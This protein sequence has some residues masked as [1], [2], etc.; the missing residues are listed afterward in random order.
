MNQNMMNDKE[1]RIE[2]LVN[3]F[4]TSCAKEMHALRYVLVVVLMIIGGGVNSAWGQTVSSGLYYIASGGNDGTV[5]QFVYNSNT[6]ETNFYLCP[7]ENWRYFKSESPYY[8]ES[9]NG[10]PF[11][12]TYQCLNDNNYDS[13]NALWCIKKKEDTDYYY[14]IHLLDGKYLT[15]NTKIGHGCNQGRMRIHLESSPADD[16]DALF[17]ITYV[18]K[19]DCYDIKTKKNDGASDDDALR[20]YMNVSGGNK[21]SKQGA[22]GKSDGP[23]INGTGSQINVGG[24]I[25]LWTY[26]AYYPS[27]ESKNDQNSRWCP[28]S[29]LLTAPTISDVDALTSKV[30][31][32][33]NNSLPS[34]YNI[35]YTTNGDDPTA[36]S[37]IMSNGVYDVTVSC[38]LKVVLERYGVVLTEVAEKSVA[39]VSCATP[40]ISFDYTTS[41]VSITCA[42][43]GANI[44]YTTDGSNPTASSTPYNNTP[45]SVTS[46]TTIK[47][48]AT[49]TTLPNSEVATLEIT[50][51]ATPTIQNNGSNAISI[52]S[53]TDGATIYY[54]IDG[55]NPTTASTPYTVPLT[56][57]VSG[58]TIKAIAVKENMII[59]EVG[60]G[61][62]TLQCADPVIVRSGNNGFTISCP[63]P[64]SGVTIYYTTNGSN[65]T[66]SSSSTTSGSTIPCTL[67][68]TVNA[69]A[70]ATNYNNSTVTSTYLTQG[71]GGDGSDADP[72]TIEYQSDV[73]DFNTKANT[74]AE[75]SKHYKVIATGSLDFSGVDITRDFSGTFDGGLC[76][77][78]GL[79]HALFNKVNGGTV[80]NVILKGVNIQS[81]DGDGDAGAICNKAEGSSVI[82]NCGILPTTT[83]R[84]DDG[85]ITGF[86]GST[87]SGNRN[88]GGLVGFLNGTSRVINCYSY[89]NIMGGSVKAGIVGY[90]NYA[91]KYNDLKTMV[92]NCMFYGNIATG[93]SVYP[94]YGGL[95][96]SNDYKANT[97]NRLNNYNYF[98]YE[99]PF[100]KN[101]HTT[102]PT[103]TA[104]NCALAAEERYL[105]RFEFYRHLLNSN[106]ELAAWYAT[107]D[108]ANG[109]GIGSDNKMLKWVLD[110]SIAPY[111]ILKV[112][113]KYPSVVNYD[114]EYTYNSSGDKVT[115]ASVT[116][117]NKG[118]IVSTL[119]SSG[120][121][122]IN[123]QMGSGGAIFDKPTG[124]SITTASLSRPIIDKDFD[125]YNFNYGKVQLPYY[126]EVGTKNY[127]G[128][129][130][131]T[132]WKIVSMT[133]GTSGGY[134]ETDY[135][136]PNYNY[137]DRD[138]YGKDIYGTGGSGR[139]F[140][141]GAYF[142]V[143]TGVTA[144][145]IEPYW[146][147]CA[148]LSNKYYDRYGYNTTDDL[149]QIGGSH[150]DATPTITIDGSAQ[151]VYTTLA[152]ARSSM[153]ETYES[154]STVYDHAIV[155]VG[156]YHH[157]TNDAAGEGDELNSVTEKP[158]TITSVDLNE[159]NEPDYCL[160]FRSG[161]QKP[162]APIRYDFITV[163]G[164]A[165]A[166]K[167]ATHDNLAI[168]GNCKPRGW[169]E[170]TTT[171]L[172]KFGQFEHSWEQKTTAPLILMGGIFDQ[173]V[174]NN[175]GNGITY[176][177]RTNYIL[178][179]DNV[180]F[181]L[182]SD[183][184][185]SD[186]TSPTP[187]RPISITGGEFDVL[188]L[189]GYFKP[190][191]TA[192]TEGNGD[193]NAKCYIDGGKFGEVAGAGQ[194]KIDGDVT[195]II[196]HADID[197]F[198]GGGINSAKAITGNI[199]T[200]IK[201]SHVDVFCGGPKFGNMASNKTVVTEA[202]G[203][204]FRKYFGGGFGGT[205][206]Y[207]HRF[208][209]Q[210][211]SLNYINDGKG[212][213]S[214]WI[215]NSYDGSSTDYYR[216]KY[217]SGK[218]VAVN[219][220]YEFFGGS[221]G[222]VAR[223]YIDYASFSLAQTNG[224]T[225]TLTGCTIKEN[226]YGGGSLGAVMGDATSTLTNCTV[227][228]KVFGAGYSVDI[229]TV[230]VRNL[231]GWSVVPYY[232]NSTAVFEEPIWQSE[233]T[234][235]WDTQSVSVGNNALVDDGLKIKTNESL[236]GLG[237][238]TGNVT[239][240]L[241]G[242]TKVGY[243]E[244]GN[245][246][247]GGGN[248]YGGGEA[249]AV[250]GSGH[251]VTV[252]LGGS[253]TV[254]GDVF[255]G[256]DQGEVEGSTK[257]NIMYTEPTP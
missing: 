249:S 179:G 199:H 169:F 77:L 226:F 242:T 165:M 153:G 136:A 1:Q 76:V 173:F 227:L 254:L 74:A 192:C 67:P 176:T 10:M 180:W 228:G 149:S 224:V 86:T 151:T 148:Y 22:S 47:A 120:S 93:G 37:T 181:Q 117:P 143:P 214:N 108:A 135:D 145:T 134:T 241:N 85:N 116:E 210:W 175:S 232:N 14:I 198:Y 30:T 156:N 139:I 235:T 229:P 97:A 194:E 78:T 218:G 132:G 133:G 50:Q 195:W 68:I 212:D 15:R 41:E 69:F 166:L 193:R 211:E 3:R 55:T 45:F 182:L 36:S 168:P 125:Q 213:W 245:P 112:Q 94:I 57:N 34:G 58:V 96:I 16:D 216:G 159:D 105:V 128:N 83:N 118:G 144:I 147:K 63:F 101:N 111:P 12:T 197:N 8:Q 137:A 140:A 247:D 106:R 103:I 38:T 23:K 246:V 203:C 178:L 26:G 5:N 126:N 28:K 80:K 150:Y 92:M 162:V 7:T 110:K 60:S 64:A 253:T 209:N 185:H 231:G 81:G 157:H 29:T 9:D 201:N 164:M 240:T 205:S 160:I 190:E 33:D 114:E 141:Q 255:G 31:I 75:A 170:V 122:T 91:S 4:M 129:R 155:L 152:S 18:S 257:V 61:S 230:N 204:T 88:V 219:Y 189:S 54:T 237:A 172:I 51:V 100:S 123:I 66:T 99:A 130:V 251:T 115:R 87:V 238:V 234:Y 19:F 49:H 119:G 109:K 79:S 250:K 73:S 200:T 256:G 236:E 17:T 158:L 52:T 39:P 202:T 243:D 244:D 56:E 174:S 221:K 53:A 59:S 44:Y 146:A 124:A 21:N 46:P 72:Y 177:N 13:K 62:V 163:P 225:S 102:S 183:G 2:R 206:I 142:N 239:L 171:G 71:M 95:E 65:P 184:T 196:D 98:L 187:H 113:D 42:T 70:V 223:L 217:I 43:A 215:S 35:R 191:A 32:T 207:R 222:N 11:M 127:T 6:P 107:G 121:L 104:Y 90:N 131:V 186:K 25:G 154:G 161:K 188:Y 84:D 233:V 24:I 82:Y 220:E 138:H 248:V 167:M 40:V 208:E 252:N 89:A 48:I 20:Q 27:N